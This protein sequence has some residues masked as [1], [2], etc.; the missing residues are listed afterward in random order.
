MP[1]E[2]ADRPS[3]Q[4]DALAV[5][6]GARDRNDL[7]ALLGRRLLGTPAPIVRVKRPEPTIVEVVDDLANELGVGQIQPRD[8]RR[9][10][11]P[12]RRPPGSSPGSASSDAYHRSPVASADAP[13]AAPTPATNTSGARTLTSWLGCIPPS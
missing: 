5:G 4:R 10:A 7:V 8:L 13:R 12:S 3:R 2:L 9:A 6:A 11:S 1:C